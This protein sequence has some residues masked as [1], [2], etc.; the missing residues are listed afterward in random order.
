FSTN[1]VVFSFML[2]VKAAMNSYETT[3]DGWNERY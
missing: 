3:E 2:A 1:S